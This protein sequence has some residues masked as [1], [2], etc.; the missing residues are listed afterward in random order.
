MKAIVRPGEIDG[1]DLSM[2]YESEDIRIV[3]INSSSKR[4]NVLIGSCYP[5]GTATVTLYADENTLHVNES[6]RGKAT[7]ISFPDM[8]DWRFVSIDQSKYETHITYIRE[9][10]RKYSHLETVVIDEKKEG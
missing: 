3:Y 2:A 5:E 1:I 9:G 10:A 7:E 6:F 4:Y 8:S